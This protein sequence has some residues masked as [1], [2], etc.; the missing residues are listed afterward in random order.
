M[1][2]GWS[3]ESLNYQFEDGGMYVPLFAAPGSTLY[4]TM[5]LSVMHGVRH[6]TRLVSTSEAEYLPSLPQNGKYYYY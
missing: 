1:E 5:G 6:S 3:G 4:G 2:R